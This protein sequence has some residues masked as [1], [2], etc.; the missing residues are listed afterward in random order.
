MHRSTL[1]PLF[2]PCTPPIWPDEAHGFVRARRESERIRLE[3]HFRWPASLSAPA[4]AE[5]HEHPVRPPHRCSSRRILRRRTES[6]SRSYPSTSQNV[7]TNSRST[8]NHLTTH[9]GV[10]TACAI[11]AA[12]ARLS[13]SKLAALKRAFVEDALSPS[14]AAQA[15]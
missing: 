5:L 8:W 6:F 15:T 2:R 7:V 10:G 4:G 13:S 3:S 12:M 9:G 1:R 14:Q 11:I